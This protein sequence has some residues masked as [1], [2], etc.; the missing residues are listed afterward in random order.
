MK[1]LVSQLKKYLP[2]LNATI[3]EICDAFTF[4][5]QMLD[6]KERV[7]FNEK[8]DWL[9][10]L[11]VRQ[12][13]ADCLGVLG[14]AKELSVIFRT[15]LVIQNNLISY[16]IEKNL[17]ISIEANRSVKRVLAVKICDL[18]I[19]ESSNWLKNYLNFYGINSINSLVD[20]TNY[21][22]I[23][24]GFPSH[25]FDSDQIGEHLVWE[26]NNN[27]YKKFVTLSGEEIDLTRSKESLVI[28][29]G[30]EILSLSFIGGQNKSLNKDSKNVILEMGIYD[31]GLVRRNSRELN[32]ITEAGQRLEKYLDPKGAEQ[33][34]SMLINLILENIG[35]RVDS[36][37]FDR[38][39]EDNSSR[40]I[41]LRLNK[42]SEIA[43]VEV[44]KEFIIE[45]LENLGFGLLEF[46]ENNLKLNV[47][48][49]RM[50]IN[51]EEDV[52]EEIIRIFGYKNIIF[53]NLQ[54]DVVKDITPRSITI[55]DDL[56]ND[57]VSRGYDEI[58]SWALVSELT[59][60]LGINNDSKVVRVLNSINDE[61]PFLRASLIGGLINR[62]ESL[63]NKNVGSI[64]I[65]EVGKI[66]EK[67]N[68]EYI[69]TLALS[70]LNNESFEELIKTVEYTLKRR[71]I[72]W[73]F[74]KGQ[75][76]GQPLSAHPKGFFKIYTFSNGR[77][78][79]IGSVFI[80][81]K[82]VT[83]SYFVAE[84]NVDN[85][86][87][88]E[89]DLLDT[90]ELTYK[91]V[92]FDVNVVAKNNNELVTLLYS[93]LKNIETLWSW[94]IV[95]KFGDKYT[96]RITYF[97]LSDLKAKELHEKIFKQ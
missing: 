70:I 49:N 76:S 21:V 38:F 83:R 51:I 26:L 71:G 72:D 9:L 44:S 33:A 84:L 61:V 95:D 3:E 94:N 27:K 75:S 82:N 53:K 24:T 67:E 13:R 48:I 1:V 88:A 64:N 6:K 69:E 41:L 19:S 15:P 89:Q 8:E 78:I 34:F 16:P 30:N 63:N 39:N 68:D 28:S 32:I 87:K 23:E 54:L 79:E 43:G 58:R 50:D 46:N 57:L 14:L 55:Q 62:A 10:D 97:G 5:G 60:A 25:V 18:Q 7:V 4:S 65:F 92:S 81:K 35:G 37:L 11:E 45:T 47:P 91:L 80:T 59:N 12:N 36:S 2:E 20:L 73:I 17:P 93:T 56:M 42:V 31:G 66:F 22:M 96:L 29:N 85:I 74:F 77:E 40:E 90:F 52:I 86:I